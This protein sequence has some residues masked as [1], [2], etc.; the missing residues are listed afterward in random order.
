VREKLQKN[1]NL[2]PI[3][4]L[5][6]VALTLF[7]MAY[8]SKQDTGDSEPPVYT[9]LNP[10]GDVTSM[11]EQDETLWVGGKEGVVGIDIET[12]TV[13]EIDSSERMTYTRHMLLDGETLWIGHDRGLTWYNSSGCKT[14]SSED[15]MVDDRVNYLMKTSDDTLWAGTWHGAYF[16]RGGEWG[17]ITVSDG[18]LDNYV[19]VIYEDSHGNLWYGSYVAPNGGISIHKPNGEWQYFTTENGLV[20]NNIVQFYEDT[21]GSI[22]VSTGLMTVGA[23]IRFEWNDDLWQIVEVLDD[24]DGVPLGKIRSV[25]RDSQGYLWVGSENDGLAIETSAGFKI[26]RREDGLSHDEVKV[27]YVDPYGSIWLGTRDG[28]TIMTESDLEEI[29]GS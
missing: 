13:F 27:Y 29:R 25:F 10:P 17:R 4:V 15:G 6:L 14:L 5:A 21:D 2:T 8:I 11:V 7:G 16:Y 23:A 3:I 1:S 28:L 22:W 26:L 24:A 12:H 19:N 9:I 18:L 20:H